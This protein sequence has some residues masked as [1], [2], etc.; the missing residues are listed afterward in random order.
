MRKWSSS[1]SYSK[2]SRL[3]STVDQW[4]ATNPGEASPIRTARQSGHSFGGADCV[5]SA[6]T[7]NLME[8]AC[9][10]PARTCGEIS[11]V[12]CTVW[13]IGT[14]LVVPIGSTCTTPAPRIVSCRRD[15]FLCPSMG[16]EHCPLFPTTR[17]KSALNSAETTL[18]ASHTLGKDGR[19]PC[20][21]VVHTVHIV[22]SS[23]AMIHVQITV[24][25]LEKRGTHH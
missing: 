9:E 1:S 14:W 5:V 7:A 10:I 12:L 17:S 24:D 6:S 3:P 11:T 8:S 18:T 19:A 23:H 15:S 4:S 21:S 25:S 22:W 2:A 13:H 16:G 20:Q